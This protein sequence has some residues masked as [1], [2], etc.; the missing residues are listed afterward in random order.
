MPSSVIDDFDYEAE[1]NALTIRF[2]SGRLYRYRQ[3]P[4]TVVL[5]FARARSKGAF[6]NRHIRD[7]YAVEELTSA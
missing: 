4:E 1:S 3:V 7:R 6:F 2:K 5:A